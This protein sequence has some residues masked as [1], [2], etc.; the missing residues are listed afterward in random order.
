MYDFTTG[1]IALAFVI[2]VYLLPTILAVINN[3]KN[4]TAIVIVN[5]F[6]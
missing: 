5:I 4:K 6:T 3:K 2:L 1:M